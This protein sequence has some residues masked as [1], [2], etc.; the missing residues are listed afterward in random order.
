MQTI[1]IT[2]KRANPLMTLADYVSAGVSQCTRISGVS[3]KFSAEG[4]MVLTNGQNI[5]N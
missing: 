5:L 1:K 3:L 4:Q 2:E